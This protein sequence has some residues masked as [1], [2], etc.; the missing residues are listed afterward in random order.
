MP[1]SDSIAGGESLALMGM[2]GGGAGAEL[3]PATVYDLH[4]SS[5]AAAFSAAM[6]A[7]W[8]FREPLL[9]GAGGCLG[10]LERADQPL[11]LLS[12]GCCLSQ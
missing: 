4:R 1:L 3:P 11:W 5:W 6:R 12:A 9:G 8:G 7:A 10:H 2:L